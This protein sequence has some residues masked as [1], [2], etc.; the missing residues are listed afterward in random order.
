MAGE[1]EAANDVGYASRQAHRCPS[2]SVAR[3]DGLASGTPSLVG[4][5]SPTYRYRKK[6]GGKDIDEDVRR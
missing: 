2:G 1:C 6:D 3:G 4:A 5:L